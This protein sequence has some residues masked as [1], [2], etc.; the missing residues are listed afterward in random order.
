MSANLILL[1]EWAR[2]LRRTALLATGLVSLACTANSTGEASPLDRG[3]ICYASHDGR[4]VRSTLFV[5]RNAGGGETVLGV[6]E[7]RVSPAGIAR[8]VERAKLDAAGKLV[9]LEATVAS[10]DGEPDARIVLDAPSGQVQIATRTMHVEWRVPN[11]LPWVWAP[12]LTAPATRAP[13]ATPVVARVELRAV[14]TG[15]PVRVIDLGALTSYAVA[16]D[17]L[18]VRDVDAVGA[19]VV[20]ANDA[21]QV[22]DGVPRALHLAALGTELSPIDAGRLALASANVGC[23]PM[24]RSVNP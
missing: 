24:E 15:S 10:T 1:C 13:I 8:A 6:T 23:A 3:P 19:T 20:V 21:V 5:R 11:D 7:V 18:V 12:I 4:L 2:R 9:H 16:A 14:G 22:E 17:Q